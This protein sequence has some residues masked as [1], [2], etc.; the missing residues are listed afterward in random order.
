MDTGL[1]G[2]ENLAK[3]LPHIRLKIV[4]DFD[5]T[6]ERL[7]TIAVPWSEENEAFALSSSHIGIA[8]MPDNPWTRG[9][10]GLK[11]LQYMAAGLP[12]VSTVRS[13]NMV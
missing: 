6:S 3:S 4:A 13:L 1:P 9:K 10:C 8:P 12:V 7:S 5:L 11:V 2:L